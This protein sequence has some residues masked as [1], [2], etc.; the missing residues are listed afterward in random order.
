MASP[1]CSALM[2]L[3]LLAVLIPLSQTEGTG[4][5]DFFDSASS[6]IANNAN[7]FVNAGAQTG[8]GAFNTVLDAFGPGSCGNNWISTGRSE[9]LV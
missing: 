8:T 1:R 7:E 2:I 6:N 9:E 5:G 3:L 4:L